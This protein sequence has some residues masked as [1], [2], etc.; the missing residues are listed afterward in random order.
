[1]LSVGHSVHGESSGNGC[2]ATGVQRGRTAYECASRQGL[3]FSV[4]PHSR[5]VIVT[6]ANHAFSAQLRKEEHKSNQ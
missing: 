1:V 2:R 4:V 5:I 3:M 6:Q